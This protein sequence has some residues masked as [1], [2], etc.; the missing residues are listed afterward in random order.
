MINLL[1]ANNTRK[2]I[3]IFRGN[4]LMKIEKDKKKAQRKTKIASQPKGLN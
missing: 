2:C 1:K 3:E 4:K